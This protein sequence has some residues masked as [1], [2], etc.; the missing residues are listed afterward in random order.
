VE[1]EQELVE[2]Q[3]E[4]IKLQNWVY[5]NNKRVMIIFEGRDA[6]GKGG[7]IKRF[8]QYLNP[9][10]FRVAALPKSQQKLRWDSSIFK[11][12]LNICRILAKLYFLIEVGI[13][14]Q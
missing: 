14:E 13:T 4:L 8:I 12:I 3:V 6:A 10:K 2:L 7:A 9:R 5:D 11:D 1:Y